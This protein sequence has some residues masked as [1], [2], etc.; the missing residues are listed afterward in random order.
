MVRNTK[1]RHLL[2]VAVVVIALVAG[3]AG[4]W[5]ATRGSPANAAAPS[6]LVS[7]ADGTIEQTVPASGTLEPAQQANLDFAV[8]G[9]VSAVDVSVGQTVASGAT[10]A[11]L[12]PTVLNASLA[13]AEASLAA[14]Q[15]KVAADQAAGAPAPQ[16]AADDAAVTA[17]Q[18]QVSQ[19]QQA[20]A[21]ATLTSP[22]A[23]IVAGVS[24]TVGQQVTGSSGA[25]A[26][27][28]SVAVGTTAGTGAAS[29]GST[30]AQVVVVATGSWIVQ[31][32]V[33]DSA[34]ATL[35]TGDQAV[36]TPQ[37]ATAPVF[38][39]VSTIGLVASQSAG[40]ATFPV[41][42]AVTGSPAGLYAGTTANV[43]IIV[44]QL[45]GVLVVPTAALRVRGGS[46]FVDVVRNGR[47]VT[48]PVA[49]GVTSGPK[50]Q[51]TSGL[52]PG[53]QVVEQVLR[54]AGRAVAAGRG[55]GARGARGGG[56]RGRGGLGGGG[57]GGGGFGGGGLAGGG[58]GGGG[59][60]GGGG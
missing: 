32:A 41:T 19:A 9:V 48:Q 20:L 1:S 10:L 39:T 49:V 30:T 57:F 7:A 36:V 43:S 53:E 17:A 11:S 40:V 54:P 28:S 42:V 25:A 26:T 52:S 27:S 14:D 35:R 18:A 55:A 21:E 37:G 31:A 34:I 38:G 60:G 45:T 12:D 56:A 51:I 23:G 6:S 22:I 47:Q 50:T 58:R 44:K 24:L 3:A 2:L 4:A 46:T 8:P 29:T 15:A 33:T 59:G 5:F 16:I 13:Q